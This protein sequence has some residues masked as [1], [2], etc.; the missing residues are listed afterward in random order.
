MT[1]VS[2]ELTLRG[3]IHCHLGRNQ[4]Q[5]RKK[6]CK[7]EFDSCAMIHILFCKKEDIILRRKYLVVNLIL[8]IHNQVIVL[9]ESIRQVLS[10]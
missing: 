1:Q 6:S 2:R 3:E 7:N 10:K 9:L 8:E 5:T 4:N